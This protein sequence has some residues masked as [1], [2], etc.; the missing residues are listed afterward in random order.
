MSDATPDSLKEK[1]IPLL[2]VYTLVHGTALAWMVQGGPHW[3]STV[4]SLGALEWG[5]AA[6]SL[7]VVVVVLLM[8]GLAGSQTKATIVF[9]RRKDPLP[10]TRFSNLLGADPRID[11]SRLT[12]RLGGKL[13]ASSGEQG[14][15]WY[16]IYR[17]YEANPSV[18]A[19]H[20][21]YLLYRDLAWMA[22]FLAI[23]GTMLLIAI[24]RPA[25]TWLLGYFL[26]SVGLYFLFASAAVRAAERLVLTVLA[27][28]SASEA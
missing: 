6:G 17:K 14:K 26:A 25:V 15:V 23:F 2:S 27:C 3:S 16:K 5:K 1:N 21:E 24:T 18:R 8:N 22:L 12:D 11:V 19:N 10:S 20:K 28:E 13:P 7:V 4:S 9:W